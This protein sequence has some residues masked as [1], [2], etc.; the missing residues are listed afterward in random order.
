M[1]TPSPKSE[2]DFSARRRLLKV[3][4]YVPPAVLGAMVLNQS[5]AW[6]SGDKGSKGSKDDGSKSGGGSNNPS[7][8]PCFCAPCGRSGGKNSKACDDHRGGCQSSSK[9]SK[10]KKDS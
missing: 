4:A 6:A 2:T 8:A 3:G 7:C 1:P 5:N 9:N 10:D